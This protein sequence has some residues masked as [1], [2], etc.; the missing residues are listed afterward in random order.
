M[1]VVLVMVRHLLLQV[2]IADPVVVVVYQ[3][4]QFLA[5]IQ[6]LLLVVMVM[7]YLQQQQQQLEQEV[8]Q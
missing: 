2:L 5:R 1:M 7:I 8:L 4:P 3:H 6:M